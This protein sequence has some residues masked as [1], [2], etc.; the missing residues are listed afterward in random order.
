M[1]RAPRVVFMLYV[2][3]LI[4]G[5]DDAS[6][7]RENSHLRVVATLHKMVW[8]VQGV[9]AGFLQ[10]PTKKPQSRMIK[11]GIP[12]IEQPKKTM[13]SPNSAASM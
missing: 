1:V 2:L 8:D 12:L 9:S 3:L 13:K 11:R 5:S 10:A 4:C 7:Q 6:A